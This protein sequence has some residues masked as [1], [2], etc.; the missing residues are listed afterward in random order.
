[1]PLAQSSGA[2]SVVLSYCCLAV[3]VSLCSELPELVTD[4]QQIFY[5]VEILVGLFIFELGIENIVENLLDLNTFDA[6]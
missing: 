5:F 4:N 6:R 1:M 3:T 2:L